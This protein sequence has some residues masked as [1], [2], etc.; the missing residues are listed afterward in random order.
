LELLSLL[1]GWGILFVP[2]GEKLFSSLQTRCFQ[3]VNERLNPQEKCEG[4]RK[5][6]SGTIG[7]SYPPRWLGIREYGSWLMV[8]EPFIQ[9]SKESADDV[10]HHQPFLQWSVINNRFI[11]LLMTGH[12]PE[13]PFP[14]RGALRPP[15]TIWKEHDWW[16]TNHA[17]SSSLA[18]EFFLFPQ[19]ALQGL[20]CSS[21]W[22]ALEANACVVEFS[23]SRGVWGFGLPLFNRVGYGS[24]LR[25]FLSWRIQEVGDAGSRFMSLG[26]Q[27]P[28]LKLLKS[29][30]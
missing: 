17:S 19:P 8:H 10:F 4:G 25:P 2:C 7:E 22:G 20:V 5:L 14:R 16:V 30:F 24:L 1:A 29:R 27:L 12:I 9:V 26:L 23:V 13:P 3:I 6:L 28:N 18:G 11:R 21:A 15:E